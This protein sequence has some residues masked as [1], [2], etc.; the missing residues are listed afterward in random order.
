MEVVTGFQ[1]RTL[2]VTVNRVL[3]R[4]PEPSRVNKEVVSRASEKNTE[5]D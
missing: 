5:G 4:E 1:R 2:R 3:R